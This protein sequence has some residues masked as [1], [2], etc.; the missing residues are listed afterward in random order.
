MAT[1]TAPVKEAPVTPAE[2]AAPAVLVPVRDVASGRWK[3]VVG[4]EGLVAESALVIEQLSDPDSDTADQVELDWRWHEG[5]GRYMVGK[6]FHASPK[7]NGRYRAAGWEPVDPATFQDPRFPSR[8]IA[9]MGSVVTYM[10]CVLFEMP[11][12]ANEE[13]RRRTDEMRKKEQLARKFGLADTAAEISANKGEG[14]VKATAGVSSEYQRFNPVQA[15]VDSL[16]RS[17]AAID[18]FRTEAKSLGI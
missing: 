10:D 3:L 13:K 16:N 18:S 12:A 8:N 14:L 6:W 7:W 15:E 17:L 9:E 4:T 2:V 5:R 11:K 1:T